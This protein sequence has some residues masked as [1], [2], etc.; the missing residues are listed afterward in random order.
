MKKLSI[1]ALIAL[2]GIF[3]FNNFAI[4]QDDMQEAKASFFGAG[5]KFKMDKPSYRVRATDNMEDAKVKEAVN[6]DV[7]KGGLLN[8]ALYG[9]EET[10]KTGTPLRAGGKRRGVK[11][12]TLLC[13]TC[14]AKA[15]VHASENCEYC[16]GKPYSELCDKC[17]A[18]SILNACED[19]R[20]KITGAAKKDGVAKETANKE[21]ALPE[22]DTKAEESVKEDKKI[23][24]IVADDEETAKPVKKAK[25]K[26][27][28]KKTS[29][30]AAKKADKEV[31]AEPAVE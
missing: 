16:K 25:K 6:Y 18:W 2:F 24:E 12:T 20:Q 7:M 5:V 27:N 10:G 31:T 17:I 30:K 8:E 23:E 13:E 3:A 26:T 19:C 1:V 22:A 14:K 28:K 9:P 15:V 4:A 21:I 11:D 29:K